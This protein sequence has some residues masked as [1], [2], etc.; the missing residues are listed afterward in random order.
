MLLLGC[1]CA[2]RTSAPGVTVIRIANWGGASDD[3]D[4]AK[5]QQGLYA[6]FEKQNPGVK[7]VIEGVPGKEYVPKMMLAHIAGVTPDI[8]TLDA[9]SSALFMNSD[10]LRDLTPLVEHDPEFKLADFYPNIVDIARR[11]KNL[12]AIPNDFTPMVVY[13]NKRM[14]DAAKVPYPRAGWTFDDF[15][16]ASKKLTIADKQYGFAFTN[17]FP[18]WIMWLWNNGGDCFDPDCTRSSGYLDSPQNAKTLAF[19]RD[20]IDVDKSAPSLSQTAATGVDLFANGQAAMTVSGHWSMVSYSVA[21]K[22]P[23][24]KPRITLDDLGVAPLPSNVGKSSTVMY[25]SGYAIAK[26]AK[27]PDLAWKFIKFMT[28]HYSRLKLN[29]TG[30]A[31]DARIDV[32]RE[33]GKNPLEAMFLPII[34]SA[35]PPYGTRVEGFEMV[36]TQAQNAMDAV[37]KNGRD[38]RAALTKAADRIDQELAKRQIPG[39]AL[40]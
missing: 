11:G 35:R 4:F 10:M 9:S 20:M 37:L 31:V 21:P 1:A 36:E 7:V 2:P 6:E 16:A 8:L 15:R 17:W 27:H 23:D 25:E 32:S 26:L 14:F 18:G 13:Y 40:R 28:S 19:L 24:G 33:R 38:P 22:G 3:S 34:P 5:A 12:Y 29:K 39:A 30:I